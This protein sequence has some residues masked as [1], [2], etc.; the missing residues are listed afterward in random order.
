MA[1]KQDMFTAVLTRFEELSRATASPSHT[2][3][4]GEV[5]AALLGEVRRYGRTR[6]D[7]AAIDA[8]G[9][10][11][12][13]MLAD[14]AEQGWFG[15]TIPEPLGGAGLSVKAA[16]R[17]VTE[18]SSFNGSLATCVGLHSGLGLYCLIKLA[19]PA[20]QQ[21][22]LPEVAA[23]KRIA[24]F[25]ATEPNAGS[26]IASVKTMLTEDGGKLRLRGTK[27]YVTNGG[28]C[29]VLTVL[30]ASPGLGG[31]RSG[32]TVVLVDPAWPGVLRGAEEHKLGLKGSSTITIDFDDVEIP[33]DHVIGEVSKGLDHAHAALTWGRTFM[34][35]GCLGSARSALEAARA[36]T[37]ERVQFGR[38][39]DRF[40]LV[41]EQLAQCT[42]D[43]YAIESVIRLVGDLYD[44]GLGDIALDS[45]VAKIIASEGSW[46]IIDRSLQLMGG[47]GYIEDAGM[48]RRLRDV[49]V[50]RIFEGANDVLRLH[51]ASATLSWSP[52]ALQALP[53]IGGKAPAALRDA[54]ESFDRLLASVGEA[55]ARVR[56]THGFKLFDRQSLQSAM[57]DVMIPTYA[58]LAVL[59]RASGSVPSGAT[60]QTSRE[61]AVASYALDRL[62]RQ[63]R[64]AFAVMDRVNENP[65]V[66]K[67]EAVL[68]D[69]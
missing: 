32:H 37:A 63:A 52:A 4:E 44:N 54:A 23:G 39:L 24:A 29:G 2:P 19:S 5:L 35:A 50:T 60:P 47:M 58:M 20:L 10:L 41:R 62:E 65:D 31:A 17:V 18:L 53:R 21:R 28:L 66:D 33:R 64:A 59:L 22:Y 36:Y 61:L 68:A 55:L 14:V 11:G 26:D 8:R 7:S 42:A 34:A 15:L 16:T 45:T 51:M 57:A 69:G 67:V 56:K 43:L 38:T 27:C 40:P 49:R 46:N 1:S 48:A 12:R 25:A 3:Q 13:E 9:A 6:V 30:A